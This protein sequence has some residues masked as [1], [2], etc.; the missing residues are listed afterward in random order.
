MAR[1]QG[2]RLR[3]VVCGKCEHEWDGPADGPCPKCN[4]DCEDHLVRVDTARMPGN[5]KDSTW[6]STPKEAR[7]RKPIGV[8]LSDEA[9]E[10]LEKMA[11]AR[12]LSRSQVIEDLIMTTHIRG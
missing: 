2:V 7:K 1:L 12:K 9:H 6:Y 10:R 4:N 11:A 5:P 8:T 3:A